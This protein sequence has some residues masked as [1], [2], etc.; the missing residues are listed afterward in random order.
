MNILQYCSILAGI[1]KT[2][3][4]QCQ[5]FENKLEITLHRVK[6]CSGVRNEVHMSDESQEDGVSETDEKN[7]N[8]TVV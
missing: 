6:H 2:D 1:A 3:K 5:I 4:G 7:S 8:I